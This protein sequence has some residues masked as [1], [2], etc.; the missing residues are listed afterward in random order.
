MESVKPKFRYQNPNVS[1]SCPNLVQQQ[2]ETSQPNK[3][4]I[5][6]ISY[7][8]VKNSF[9]YLCVILD[10][11]LKV[12]AWNVYKKMKANLVCDTLENAVNRRKPMAS[13]LFHSDRGS[14][15]LSHQLRKIQEKLM[16]AS[17]YSKLAY[18]RDNAV[19]EPFF[20]WMKHEELKRYRYDFAK[21]ER[22]NLLAIALKIFISVYFIDIYPIK[23]Y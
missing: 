5:S 14:Q 17:S 3:V 4:W 8:P 23:A 15:Y 7:I 10:L 9:V 20:K 1:L 2:F 16:I 22:R 11:F 6:D 13:V 18:P 12:I 21:F 19:T